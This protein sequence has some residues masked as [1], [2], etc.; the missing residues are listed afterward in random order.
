[1]PTT[2][3][4]TG[5]L[6]P[7]RLASRRPSSTTSTSRARRRRRRRRPA[8]PRRAASR[9]CSGLDEQ[10]L[11]AFEVPMLLV[12]TRVPM[13]LAI[14][15]S[16]SSTSQWSICRRCRRRRRLGGMERKLAS[17]PRTKKTSRRHPRQR[18]DR[19]ERDRAL[20][21]RVRAAARSAA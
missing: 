7:E 14:C 15:K 8:A 18:V 19:H 13:T 10:Q 17:L 3:A 12:D 6:P 21:D 9:P 5:G 11:R 4:S 2:A 1:M 20:D 16:L